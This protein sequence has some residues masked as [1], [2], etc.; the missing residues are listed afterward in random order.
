MDTSC[1]S[2]EELVKLIRLCNTAHK[3]DDQVLSLETLAEH[4]AKTTAQIHN[5]LVSQVRSLEQSLATQQTSS[6]KLLENTNTIVEWLAK[7]QT[8]ADL[9]QKNSKEIQSVWSDVKEISPSI[10][11]MLESIGAITNIFDLLHILSINTAIEASK[12]GDKGRAFAIIAKEMR[13]LAEQSRSFTSAV[14][15]RAD[16]IEKS[17]QQLL[18]NLSRSIQS[19]GLLENTMKDFLSDSVLIKDNT[20]EVHGFVARY[21]ALAEEQIQEWKE[22][23]V[24]I[25][26][27]EEMAG[28]VFDRS[29]QIESMADSLF[30]MIKDET[31]YVTKT[32]S[33]F[34]QEA[35]REVQ[36][37]AA[38]IPLDRLHDK[39]RVNETLEK[40]SSRHGLYELLYV[41]D[42]QGI[43]ISHNVYAPNYRS[44]HD[45][46][47]GYRV[48]RSS[49]DYYRIP[50]Q[51]KTPFVSNVYLSAATKA[52]CMTVAVPL[53]EADAFKGVLCADVD[54]Q[55]LSSLPC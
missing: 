33:G 39:Q 3:L 25:K 6:E 27:L 53:M 10:G 38:D 9:F 46:T 11:K 30:T 42:A 16:S 35:V 12:F 22:S 41:L 5:G 47:E 52:L 18:A 29:K 7:E 48:D 1:E 37:L 32:A 23:I 54:L 21:K 28:V 44:L 31:A 43:Q 14:T 17:L 34:H 55:F 2:A 8:V 49:K 51:T 50:R 45:T 36:D 19:H 20:Q 13:K 15:E 40:W 24:Q 4:Q 26:S